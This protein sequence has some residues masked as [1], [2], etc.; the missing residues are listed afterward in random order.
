MVSELTAAESERLTVC[1]TSTNYSLWEFQFR[2]FVEGLGL[3]GILDGTIHQPAATCAAQER[4]AWSQND[5]R[6]RSWLL[7]SVDSSTCLSLRLFPTAN[8]MWRHLAGLYSSVTTARQFEVQIA[9]SQLEQG[10]RSVTA[11]FNAAQELWT[12]QDM[13][14]LALRPQDVTYDRIIERKQGQVMQFPMRLR[15]E[16]EN[17]RS[18]ILNREELNFD[19]VLRSLVREET[20]LRTQALFDLRPGEGETIVAASAATSRSGMCPN[21]GNNSQAFAVSRPQF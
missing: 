20:R 15:P 7:G 10:G 11:Y 4:T 19:G 9:I 6:I 8:R 2:V 14:Q 5:A 3:L 16:F 12:E 1:L 17:V 21:Y 18:T 13:I